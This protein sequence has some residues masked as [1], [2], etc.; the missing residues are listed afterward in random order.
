MN[1]TTTPQD[2]IFYAYNETDLKNSD[3]IQRSI[4]GD[5]LVQQDF[6]EIIEALNTL[7]KG[8]LSPA[9]STIAK[10]LDYSR[11]TV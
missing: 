5:P 8:K 3:R 2:L 9:E 10:I 1:K 11:S 7:E 6:N 4:D